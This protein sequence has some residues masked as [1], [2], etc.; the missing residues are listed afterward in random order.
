L[1]TRSPGLN[2][3]VV[4]G[5]AYVGGGTDCAF[6]QVLTNLLSNAFKKYGSGRPID[7]AVTSDERT[8]TLAV[9]VRG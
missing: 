3:D 2:L 6:E 4:E 9:I 7:V 1:A 8:A 5:R